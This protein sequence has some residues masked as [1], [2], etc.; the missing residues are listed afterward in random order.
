MFTLY[1]Y[2]TV[3]AS[4]ASRFVIGSRVFLFSAET[5]FY[6]LCHLSP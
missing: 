4:F 1:F 5:A 2:N 6:A 3:T